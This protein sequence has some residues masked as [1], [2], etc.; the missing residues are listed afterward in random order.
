MMPYRD[1]SGGGLVCTRCGEITPPNPNGGPTHEVRDDASFV[2][3]TCL[4]KLQEQAVLHRLPIPIVPINANGPPGQMSVSELLVYGAG[5][6]LVVALIGIVINGHAFVLLLGVSVGGLLY[7]LQHGNREASWARNA[8]RLAIGVLGFAVVMQMGLRLAAPRKKSLDEPLVLGDAK[9]PVDVPAEPLS[10]VQKAQAQGEIVRREER[11]QVF[12]VYALG[13][14]AGEPTLPKALPASWRFV[15]APPASPFNGG[16]WQTDDTLTETHVLVERDHLRLGGKSTRRGVPTTCAGVVEPAGKEPAVFAA[17]CQD[18]DG[19]SSYR[20]VRV[21]LP[22]LSPLLANG[23]PSNG[24]IPAAYRGT[25]KTDPNDCKAA[26]HKVTITAS[27]LTEEGGLKLAAITAT[28]SGMGVVLG[29]INV[30]DARPCSGVIEQWNGK[31]RLTTTCE[32]R[33]RLAL[34]GP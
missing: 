2:C 17:A 8:R 30:P 29:A 12:G 19:Q 16:I 5:L 34:C 23:P 32:G 6:F 14:E 18:E 10:R 31:P 7:A 25:F 28:P 15:N 4:L 26:K 33:T 20:L 21:Q 27:T 3:A 9:A 24:T 1:G 13:L 11:A 22:E